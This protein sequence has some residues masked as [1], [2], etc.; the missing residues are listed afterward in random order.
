MVPPALRGKTLQS[1][2]ENR[3]GWT[4]S[5]RREEPGASRAD[6]V[7]TR[8]VGYEAHCVRYTGNVE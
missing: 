4:E 2:A 5:R 3:R 8:P 1:D 6:A 7:V